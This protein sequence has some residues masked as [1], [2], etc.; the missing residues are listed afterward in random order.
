LNARLQHLRSRPVAALSVGATVFAAVMTLQ[1]SGLLEPLEIEAYDQFLRRRP[2]REREWSPIVLV[3]IEEEDIRS[4]GHPLCDETLGEVVSRLLEAG[5]RA[6]GIDLYRDLPVP[7]PCGG[8]EPSAPLPAHYLGLGETITASDA[9]VMVM[10]FPDFENGGTP[11]PPF[12]E[13]TN[14]IGFNDFPIDID[15]N[16][17]VRRGLLFLWDDD[18][19]YLS[20]SLQLA[21]RYLRPEGLSILPDPDEPAFVRLGSTTIPPF[22]GND[23]AYVREDDG[24]YQ[25]LLDYRDGPGAYP[26]YTL[27]DVFSGAVGDEE[28]RDRVVI[29][30]SMATSVKD[31]FYTPFSRGRESEEL[32]PGIE[33]HGHAVSQLIRFARGEDAPIA[34]PGE[35]GEALWILVWAGLG[36]AL[37]L[38]NRSPWITSMTVLG[39]IVGLF[40]GGYHLFL[41]GIWIPVVSPVLAGT[42]ATGLASVYVGV[43]ERSQRKQVTDLFSRFLRPAVADEIWRQ[44]TAFMR[45][46]GT[47]TPRAQRLVLTTL[48]SDMKG[49]TGA[50]EEMEPEVLTAWIND[51]LNAMAELVERHGGVVD[52][53]AGDGIKANF[54]FPVPST[55]E[56]RIS[57]DAVHAVRCAWKERSLGQGRLRIGIFTG[58]ATLGAIGGRRSLK[59]TTVG[60]SIN[61]AARLEA[62]D[63]EAFAAEPDESVSRI[64]IGE[65]TLVRLDGAFRTVDLGRHALSGKR[66]ETSVYRVLGPSEGPDPRCGEGER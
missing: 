39:S 59:Y 17:A 14:Q 10:K 31:R 20:F 62:F 50:S 41:H 53:Y 27:R 7:E 55:T 65:E 15:Q 43:T 19:P 28:L 48:F 30:G 64:L 63:K 56:E 37:G 4:F 29:L 2:P 25:F 47:A 3:A 12:L 58:P 9:I 18:V 35:V 46:D 49:F 5:P 60:D 45:G 13:G 44:R 38:W 16:G 54:G 40:A 22:Q 42:G 61:V 34:S 6:L 1:L 51:Y 33:I 57:A 23:G 52:D 24:G 26:T 8:R 32:M 66:E 36:T 11:P 21:L